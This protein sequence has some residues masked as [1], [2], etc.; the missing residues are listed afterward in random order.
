[1]GEGFI[2]QGVTDLWRGVHHPPFDTLKIGTFAYDVRLKFYRYCEQWNRNKWR[3]GQ[4][5]WLDWLLQIKNSNLFTDCQL[6]VKDLDS[7]NSSKCSWTSKDMPTK[8]YYDQFSSRTINIL[9]T[10]HLQEIWGFQQKSPLSH[11]E[12]NPYR[13]FSNS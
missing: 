4:A 7:L 12:F 2:L 10:S 11:G 9:S 5:S 1:M 6:F 13:F 8:V 3:R